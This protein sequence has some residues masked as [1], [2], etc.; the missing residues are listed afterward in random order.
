MDVQQRATEKD[1]DHR[2]AGLISLGV[3]E[4]VHIRLHAHLCTPEQLQHRAGPSLLVRVE[5][6]S[7]RGGSSKGQA[8]QRF[9]G[10][11]LAQGPS[12]IVQKQTTVQERNVSSQDLAFGLKHCQSGFE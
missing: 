8:S 6:L 3:N 11:F 4:C 7:G 5:G 2:Q 1:T 12:K 9:P 10:S